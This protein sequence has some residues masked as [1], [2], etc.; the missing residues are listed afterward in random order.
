MAYKTFHTAKTFRKGNKL[1]RSEELFDI[2]VFVKL[3]GDHHAAVFSLTLIDIIALRVRQT[4]IIY[5][6]YSLMTAEKFCRL[7]SIFHMTVKTDAESFYSPDKQEAVKRTENASGRILDEC[8]LL[9]KLIVIYNNK[10]GYNITVTAEILCSTMDNDI[11][12]ER[13]RTL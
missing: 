8:Y 9:C 2:V 4:G 10:S 6:L 1:Q 7:L 11:N 12:S 5:L 13:N 3:K